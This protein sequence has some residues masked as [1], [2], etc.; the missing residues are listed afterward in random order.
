MKAGG[1]LYSSFC[2]MS[3]YRNDCPLLIRIA[4]IYSVPVLFPA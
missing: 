1:S 2:H 3:Q 4:F